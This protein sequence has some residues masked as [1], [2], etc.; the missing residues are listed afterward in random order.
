MIDVWKGRARYRIVE[1]GHFEQ[2]QRAELP[3]GCECHAR[4]SI[5]TRGDSSRI[6]SSQ[7]PLGLQM[8]PFAGVRKGIRVEREG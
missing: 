8:A 6:G 5:G 4:E 7:A 3:R 1:T 2:S